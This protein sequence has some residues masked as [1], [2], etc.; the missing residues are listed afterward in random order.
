MSGMYLPEKFRLDDP[1][2]LLAHARAHPFAT[3]I[4]HGE[5]GIAVSHLPL[6]VEAGR[7]RGHLARLNPQFAQFEAGAE[8]VAV[9]H[10]PHAY[11]SPSVYAEQPA[12]PTWN[13]VVVHATGRGRLTGER[14]LRRTL[15][16]QVALFDSTGWRFD[17]PEEYGRRMLAQIAGFEI[18]V[19][20]LEGKWKLS[21]NRPAEDQQRVAA[22]LEQGDDAGRAVAA[23]M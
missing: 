23:L 9:F 2:V 14:E 11:V 5:G 22:W 3:V 13:Y 12:V 15:D 19:D 8:M 7:L 18:A 6:L 20:R 16:E 17:P 21:Q 10:G 4:S 1:A